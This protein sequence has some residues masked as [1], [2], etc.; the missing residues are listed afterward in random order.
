MGEAKRKNK[1]VKQVEDSLRERVRKGE[2][3][4]PGSLAHACI[5]LDKSQ[6]AADT[7]KALRTLP[8]SDVLAPALESLE[9]QFWA[10]SALFP[11]ALLLPAS[12]S[13]KERVLLAASLDKLDEMLAKA[14]ARHAEP[15]KAGFLIAVA[16]EIDGVI[17]DKIRKLQSS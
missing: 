14:F 13:G 10:T 6:Q 5:V 2:F 12:A 11:F 15:G 9:L 16:D 8:E 17:R 3:G 7:L 4:E 1:Q